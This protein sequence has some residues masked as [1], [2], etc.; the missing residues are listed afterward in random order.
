MKRWVVRPVHVSWHI[1]WLSVGILLG[2]AVSLALD[3]ALTFDWVVIAFSISLVVFARPIRGMLVLA[4]V[5]GL[6]FGLWR[7]TSER[8]NLADYETYFD[9]TVHIKGAV[10]E[11][12]SY[13]KK[14]D[15]RLRLKNIYIND[16]PM[17]GVVWVSLS[18]P[19][20]IKR[21]DIVELEGKL[22]EGFGDMSAS[23]VRP[24]L[25]A[26]ERPYPGDVARRIR[27]WFA[28]SVRNTI[29]SPQADLG[30]GFLLGQR[31]ALPDTLDKELKVTGLTHVVVASGYNL[32]ILVLF[33][34]RVFARVSKYVAFVSSSV[35][36]ASFIAIT[37]FSSSMSRAGLVSMLGLIAWYYGRKIHPLVLLSFA[38][39]IT[40]MLHPGYVWGDI[41][42]YLSFTAF[43]GV[44][45]MAPLINN[46][47]WD[48]EQ[49]PHAIR[50]LVIE[51]LSAQVMTLP[52]ILL[53][54]GYFS[55]YALAANVLVLPLI[56][57][58]MLLTFL[59]GVM[60]FIAPIIAMGFGFFA[61]AILTYMTTVIHW[62][63]SLPGAIEEINFTAADLLLGYASI[64]LLLF[65]LWS[66]ARGTFRKNNSFDTLL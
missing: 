64:T 4:L 14:G 29:P 25:L 36:I 55:A 8:V 30:L 20:N 48:K 12:A 53:V 57:C 28:D 61:T 35:L 33:S 38:A 6:I 63:A 15:Q 24:T 47:F 34:R 3:Q 23:V 65:V 56:P 41:G 22:L 43:A 45:I 16:T 26:I 60:E 10:S 9:Q 46:F 66:K 13:G 18:K 54:F 5:A 17:S 59:A 19:A 40:A 27:D 31:N 51:T 58:V 1:A 62:I 49:K 42:W 37:G 11:D 32:T 44:L 7:G 39:A 50:Q 21:G 52:I 2:I